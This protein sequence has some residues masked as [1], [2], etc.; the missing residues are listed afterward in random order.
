MNLIKI[1]IMKVMVALAAIAFVVGCSEK[2]DDTKTIGS[3]VNLALEIEDITASQ[4]KIKVTHDGDADVEWLGYMTTNTASSS[5]ELADEA[6]AAYADGNISSHRS[7][8][9]VA[10]L[11]NLEPA[12]TYKY[13][14]FAINESGNRCGEVSSVEFTTLESG[15]GGNDDPDAPDH[16]NGMTRNDAW[17]VRYIGEG[18]ISGENYDDIISVRSVD[19]NSYA[20]TIVYAEYYDP[21]DL[22]GL[23]DLLLEDMREYVTSYNEYYGTTFTI[24][25]MLSTGDEYVGFDLDP[26]FYRAVAIG[27]T[28]QG[29]VS[30]LYAVS[31]EFEVEV[32][33]ASDAYNA[34]LGK[35]SILGMNNAESEIRIEADMPNS[36]YYMTG[37]EGFDDLKVL[38]EYDE[39]LDSIFFFAQ[40]VAEDYYLSESYPSVDIYFFG[41]DDAGY[42]YSIDEGEYY[43]G[44]GGILDDG[45]RM[46]V[47]Y[48]VN[49][50][51]YPRFSQMFFMA[52]VAAEDKYHGLS[53][54]DD[55]PSFLALMSPVTE[56]ASSRKMISRFSTPVRKKSLHLDESRMPAK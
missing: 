45:A 38:V 6:L 51:G 37:W 19:N 3:G 30:G 56:A 2:G 4:A 46:I 24:A 54:E 25:D 20:V 7:K 33:V 8:Q 21:A 14:A 34:W 43:I 47:R 41:G 50:P 16:I 27:F 28:Q 23:A 10:I 15:G 39:E 13:I 1:S 18:T 11:K 40:L 29:E 44:I 48:G 42:Y 55:I 5:A 9:Y 35:W 22:R 36:T 49:T 52:Y 12:T 53:A 17:M 32:P 31:D 26:G